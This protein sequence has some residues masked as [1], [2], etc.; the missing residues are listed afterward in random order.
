MSVTAF[1][2]LARILTDRGIHKTRTG[3]IALTCASVDDV[4]AWCMLAFVIAI[5][6]S[7]TAGFVTT[8]GGALAF[9]AAM[10]FV[11]R[12]LMVRLTLVYGALVFAIVLW[13]GGYLGCIHVRCHYRALQFVV[14]ARAVQRLQIT[15]GRLKIDSALAH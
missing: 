9:I 2:V 8:F 7:R 5:I 10:L 15:V 14:G 13:A 4:T 12:P 3:A 1:P 6:Q 11:M